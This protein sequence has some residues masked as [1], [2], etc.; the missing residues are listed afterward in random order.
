MKSKGWVV[1]VFENE[2]RHFENEVAYIKGPFE[3]Y[4]CAEDWSNGA[5]DCQDG[6]CQITF[7]EEAGA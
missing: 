4:E 1:V 7:I 6:T 5:E 3:T 2:H